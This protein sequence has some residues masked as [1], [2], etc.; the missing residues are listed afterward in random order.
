MKKVA[1][2][3]NIFV[4]F[5]IVFIFIEST[6]I[7]LLLGVSYLFDHATMKC[8]HLKLLRWFCYW[9]VDFSFS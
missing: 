4:V 2:H 8:G 7:L 9:H 5:K 1:A 6:T 3:I